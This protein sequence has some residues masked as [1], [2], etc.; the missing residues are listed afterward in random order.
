MKESS[1]N[2][3]TPSTKL[4]SI[5]SEVSAVNI[6]ISRWVSIEEG[7]HLL[8]T[9]RLKIVVNQVVGEDYAGRP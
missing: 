9:E 1:P 3:T 6:G 5:T 2:K 7:K 4:D 8:A